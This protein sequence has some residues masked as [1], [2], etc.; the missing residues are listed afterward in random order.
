MACQV[1]LILLNCYM[2]ESSLITT[3]DTVKKGLLYFGIFCV[4]AILLNACMGL[5]GTI[6]KK[7][8]ANTVELNKTFKDLTL[9]DMSN[10][11]IKGDNIVYAL[12]DK[13]VPIAS[14]AVNVYKIDDS[15]SEAALAKADDLATKL[16]FT[17]RSSS[18]GASLVWKSGVH[19]LK[20]DKSTLKFSYFN[21]SALPE[22]KY[23]VFAPEA[24]TLTKATQLVKDLN[25][26][27][28][29]L[30]LSTLQLS[31]LVR[32]GNSLVSATN[33]AQSEYLKISV[34][35]N[36][37]PLPGKETP[38]GHTYLNDYNSAPLEIIITSKDTN[39]I[40]DNILR[41]NLSD[42]SLDS[43]IGVYQLISADEAWKNLQAGQAAIKEIYVSGENRIAAGGLA[44]RELK[45]IT[46]LKDKLE[47][48]YLEPGLTNDKDNIFLP[49]YV[50]RGTADLTNG[51]K[52][53]ITI[54][55]Y[56]VKN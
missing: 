49:I 42:Y 35:R 9:T 22:K 12:D 56:A 3:T 52:A 20:F 36:L 15:S 31:W 54:F 30:D 28:G 38:L 39:L 4:V 46:I 25:L 6:T 47:L 34:Y 19:T 40:V 43:Q 21:G 50:F 48:A 45:S 41:L 33:Q 5:L 55:T 16:K 1:N 17:G 13:L 11:P 23:G 44:G 18:E 14:N 53:D 10:I 37:K 51:K 27:R 7:N 2:A 24:D 26:E 29:Q 8:P 32:Q